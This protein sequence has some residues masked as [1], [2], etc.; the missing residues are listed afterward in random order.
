MR[1]VCCR[2]DFVMDP[3]NGPDDATSH[4]YCDDCLP[5]VIQEIDEYCA[6][7]KTDGCG[8]IRPGTLTH[9]DD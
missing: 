2:C 5:A 8:Y 1:R 9:P 3:G 6:R 4:G 7:K